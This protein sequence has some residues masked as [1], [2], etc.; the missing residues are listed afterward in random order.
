MTARPIDS[1]VSTYEARNA[2]KSAIAGLTGKKRGR[3]RQVRRSS[4]DIDDDRAQVFRRIADGSKRGG[5]GWVDDVLRLANEYDVVH[6]KPGER[7]PLQ[8]NAIRV[9]EVLLRKFLD[10]RT[11]QLDP[12]LTTLQAATGLS[13]NAIVSAMKRLKQHGFLDWVRRTVTTDNEGGYGPQRAQTSNAYFVSLKGL[14]K[15][16]L[17]RFLDLRERRRRRGDPGADAPPLPDTPP[18]RP[19]P[20][21]IAHS[22]L[23]SALASLA[24]RVEDASSQ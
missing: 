8:A 24:A 16:V 2:V 10:F 9:L 21:E 7:G 6:K 5:L 3:D 22:G 12:A 14:A 13:R 1:G 17:R 18:S 19:E 15:G 11:G 20:A 23:A 4:Y